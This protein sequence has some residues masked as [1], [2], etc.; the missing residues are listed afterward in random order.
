MG[1]EETVGRAEGR[2][3]LGDEVQRAM[4]SAACSNVWGELRGEKQ[5]ELV[6]GV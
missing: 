4:A 1:G 3:L 5:N 6:Q 2:G